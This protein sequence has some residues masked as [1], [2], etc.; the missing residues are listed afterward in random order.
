MEALW[1]RFL[2][3]Y[4]TVNDWL[5]ANAIGEIRGM[6]SSFCFNLPFDPDSRLF[7]P[8]QAGGSLLDLGIYNLAITQWAL[9]A[10]GAA[11]NRKPFSRPAAGPMAG[12]RD[13]PR[14]NSPAASP[15][16]SGADTT[17]S[18]DNSLRIFGE[19]GLIRVP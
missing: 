12:H 10:A 2:P 14:C 9:Q 16:S 6:Q 11:R 8:S 5:A 13:R 1:T 4:A 19:R 7:D 17:A 15:R 18:A 3:I